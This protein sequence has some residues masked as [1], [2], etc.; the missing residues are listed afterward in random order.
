[1]VMLLDLEELTTRAFFVSASIR[2]WRPVFILIAAILVYA[3]ALRE[4]PTGLE[5]VI[6]GTW[7]ELRDDGSGCIGDMI[8]SQDGSYEAHGQLPEYG[9][10]YK[11]EGTWKLVYDTICVTPLRRTVVDIETGAEV[12]PSWWGLK[13]Y[14]DSVVSFDSNS[15][16]YLDP[17]DKSTA[18]MVRQPT[19]AL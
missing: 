18:K 3:C 14:C 19:R 2:I 4:N 9:L 7:C 16:V 6:V 10:R 17:E 13:P 11:S 8:Y 15:I 5:S 12:D 1:M